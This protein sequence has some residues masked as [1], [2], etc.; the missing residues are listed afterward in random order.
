VRAVDAAQDAY[1]IDNSPR[2]E[3]AYGASFLFNS[4]GATSND[5]P[6]DI[7]AGLDQSN[8]PIFGVQFRT[9]PGD[10]QQVRGWTLNNG[11]QVFTRWV[12]LSNTTHQFGV[13]WRAGTNGGFSL[14]IDRV[15]L[16]PLAG[17]SASYSLDKMYLGPSSGVTSAAWGT[18]YFDDFISYRLD[19]VY[20]FFMPW[21]VK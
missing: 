19:G 9:E 5:S 14:V 3:I 18:M 21:L 15:L 7:F 10:K 16:S 12:E 2:S 4:N 1:V 8:T 20:N 11:E 6:V 13:Y 17:N